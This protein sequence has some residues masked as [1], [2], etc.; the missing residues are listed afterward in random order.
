MRG[1]R[2]GRGRRAELVAHERAQPLEHPHSLG[3]V[4][5]CGQGLHQQHVSGVAVGLGVDQSSARALDRGELGAADPKPGAADHLERLEADI[6]ELAAVWLKP[7]RL[8]ARQEPAAGDVQWHLRRRPGAASVR[9]LE[10][11]ERA[12][13]LGTRGLEVDPDRLRE[14][15]DQLVASGERVGAEGGTYPREQRAQ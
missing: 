11:L 6:V 1:D 8:G 5:A 12:L 15:Q 3:N 7:P 14:R 13:E 9:A 10:R 2:L 4:P